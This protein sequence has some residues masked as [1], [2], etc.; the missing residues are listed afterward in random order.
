M[1]TNSTSLS[2]FV[3]P[4]AAHDITIFLLDKSFY[5]T[6]EKSSCEEHCSL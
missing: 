5:A 6:F 3:Q 1:K 4:I 2:F